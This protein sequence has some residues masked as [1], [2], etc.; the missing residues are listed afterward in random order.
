MEE[1]IGVAVMLLAVG[2]GHTGIRATDHF[3]P[4]AMH[5]NPCARINANSQKLGMFRNDGNQRAFKMTLIY[6]RNHH[7]IF[8]ESKSFM[9][10]WRYKQN[11]VAFLVRFSWLNQK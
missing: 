3:K 8:K 1:V 4:M 10:C 5:Q 2:N 7:N 6:M 9:I 11:R